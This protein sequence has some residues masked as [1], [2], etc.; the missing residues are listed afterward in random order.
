MS[1]VDLLRSWNIDP[2]AVTGHS[3]GEVSAAYAA[4]AIDFTEGLAI[5]YIRGYL[6]THILLTPPYRGGMLA[7]GLGYEDVE[8]YLARVSTGKVVV[9]CV[10]SQS[11]VTLSGDLDAVEQIRAE[12]SEKNIFARKL[13][14]PAAYHSHHMEPLVES[15]LEGLEKNLK[16]KG[17]FKGVI[18]SSPVTGDRFESAKELGPGHWVKNMVQ[19]VLFKQSLSNMLLPKTFSSGETQSVD[20]VVEVGPHGALA[21][22]I[23]QVLGTP[24]LK[25]VKVSYETCLMRGEN[26]VQT[27]QKLACSLL[28]KGYPVNL[29]AINRPQSH[30][31]PQVL[32]NL[33]PYPWNHSN[34]HWFESR[35]NK[36]YKARKYP[37]HDLVGSLFTGSNPLAHTWRH[38]IRPSE[39]PWVRDHVV[40][41]DMVYPGAG[42]IVMAIEAM[43]QILDLERETVGYY[44]KDIEIMKALVIPDTPDGVE[45]Q[46]ALQ[47]CSDKSLDPH[48]WQEFHVYSINN[49]GSW[50]EHCKGLISGKSA[51]V[52]SP[53]THDFN[54]NPRAYNKHLHP[55]DLFK[56]LRSMGIHHGPSFQNLVSIQSGQNRSV[57]TFS[58]ANSVD[59]MPAKF[60]R[61]HLLH[62]ITLDA[63]L[64]SAYAA[65]PTTAARV[66]GASIPRSI[67][68]LFVSANL[69]NAVGHRLQTFSGL[70]SQ[71]SQGFDVSIAT[72]NEGE[73]ESAPLIKIDRVYYQSLGDTA[74]KEKNANVV[75][76][77]LKAQWRPDLVFMTSND[78]IPFLSR[79]L[80][81]SEATI[82]AD[83]K[84]I[85]YHFIHDTLIALSEADIKNLDWHHRSLYT[86]MQIQD[87]KASRNELAP[88]SAKWSKASEGVKQLLFDKVSSGVMDGRLLVRIGRS[89]L[90][91]MRK[92]VS[93]MGL[94]LK[95]KILDS[96]YQK[97][98]KV[99]GFTSQ[100][101]QLVKIFGHHNPRANVLEIGA[102][103]GACTGPT[104]RALGGGDSGGPLNF[105][106]YTFTDIS[107]GYFEDA[108]KE[109]DAWGDLVSYKELDIEK[110]AA[111][112]SFLEGSF[113]L[114]IAS[115]VLYTTKDI[116]KTMKNVRKLLKLG[117]R[118][119]MVETTQ[120]ALDMQMVFGTLPEWWS[121]KF[122]YSSKGVPIGTD[123]GR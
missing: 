40:Q 64:Q 108:R 17:A 66:M 123:P 73:I 35:V 20:I 52:A 70:H 121:S 5:A 68:S 93:P 51:S 82:M 80:D 34:R 101:A 58:I 107:S 90:A 96:Y 14:T 72:I 31:A 1:L 119:I 25:N 12:L 71:N 54:A 114:V 53:L 28:R 111:E 85:T 86:W 37:P 36:E 109:F 30:T 56:S 97:G 103:S 43:R 76:V 26:A 33:P 100:V 4:G 94:M 92:Q 38:F 24:E 60:E 74:P 91:I 2:T 104:L 27:M 63:V 19:P 62:P 79:H 8:P 23:R 75:G 29:E 46:L 84:R 120:E 69:T 55:N 21:G 117:G 47:S 45:V 67:K 88:R 110:G 59:L 6:T 115:R 77:S 44:L 78:F 106:H 122:K 48:G 98:S 10:N 18:Y 15:Y 50:D 83:L 105:F 22:P 95:E 39:I 9:A 16:G 3:S 65:V 81:P 13:N 99:D 87:Q 89:L 42:C 102:G 118:L 11:S 113:D 112:Q 41:S 57:A 116:E 32:C 61:P 49:T 7:V